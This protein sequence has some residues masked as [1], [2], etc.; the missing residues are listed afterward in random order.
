MCQLETIIVLYIREYIFCIFVACADECFILIS[1]SYEY[2]YEYEYEGEQIREKTYILNVCLYSILLTD[3]YII[4]DEVYSQAKPET[5]HNNS[6][7]HTWV[8]CH[9]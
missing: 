2:E 3:Y 4:L 5:T 7:I 6:H 1:A 9:D 8:G